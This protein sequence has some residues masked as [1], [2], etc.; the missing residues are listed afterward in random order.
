[1]RDFI[2]WRCLAFTTGRA[3][4][5]MTKKRSWFF[6]GL[7]LAHL[8]PYRQAARAGIPLTGP[9]IPC[10]PEPDGEGETKTSNLGRL[11]GYDHRIAPISTD[12]RNKSATPMVTCQAHGD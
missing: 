2:V 11:R 3:L 6:A 1:M 9:G 8:L 12:L 5:H 4:V 7:G 10:G